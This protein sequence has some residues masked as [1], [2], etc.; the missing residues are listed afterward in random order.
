LSTVDVLGFAEHWL[1]EDEI[2]CYNWPNFS[3]LSKYCRK[4][5][6]NGGL[7]IYAKS[8]T[9]TKPIKNL[10]LDEHFEASVVKLVHFKLVIICIYK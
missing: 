2:S 1:L 6:K 4:T 7:C 10:N 3:L 5:E 8:N 9:L